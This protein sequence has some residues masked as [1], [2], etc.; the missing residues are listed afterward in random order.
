[1]KFSRY[2]I[3]NFLKMFFLIF[4]GAIVMFVVIDFVGNI[5][6]W[7]T[8]EMNDV[9]DYYLCYLPNIVYLISPVVLFLAVIA[10]VGNMA[11]HLELTAVQSSGRSMFR[12]LQPIFFF[13][14][15]V[16]LGSFVLSETILPEANYRRLEIMET[17]AQKRKNKRVKEKRDFAFIDSEKASWFFRHY[18]SVSKAG[19]DVLLLFKESG[20]LT[21]RFDAR[22]I[23]FESVDEVIKIFE[24]RP[25]K[26]LPSIDSLKTILASRD[27]CWLLEK[28][29]KRIFLP[30]G[31]VVTESFF[32]YP[33]YEVETLPEDFINERQTGDEMNTKEVEKRIGVLR[34]SGE[35][36]RTLETAFHFKYASPWTNFIVLL[37]GAALCHRFSRS[38]GLSQKFGIG[39]FIIFSYYIIIRLG[40]K[41]G[42]NG[43]LSPWLGAYGPHFIF[44]AIAGVL[45]YRSFRL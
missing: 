39:L 26:F 45:L 8:R 27:S 22:R 31:N 16:T 6:T 10:S 41:M 2:L 43:A 25:E 13:G 32:Y 17:N 15:L 34:R 12:A 24:R 7:L 29:F 9:V 37:I 42:E 1:M 35:D 4:I 18:S 20:Q 36:T 40:L 21:I 19:R 11:K 23:R 33:L 38:G 44:L 14:L 30:T 28:G 5:R 3:W